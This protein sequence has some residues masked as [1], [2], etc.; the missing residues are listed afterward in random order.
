MSLTP[1]AIRSR[2][3]SRAVGRRIL[4]VGSVDSTNDLAWAEAI[5]G[6]EHGLA[7]FAEEQRKGRG[8]MGREWFAAKGSSVLCSV[9]LRPEI[10]VERVPLVTAIAALAAADAVDEIAHTRSSIRFPNDVFVRDRKIAGVLVES[11]FIS[12]RPDLFVVGIG[13]NGN[14]T[15]DDFPKELAGI[16]TSLQMENGK[17]VNL[18]LAAR[19]LLEALDRWAGELGGGLR[20]IR[21]EW[22]E[23]SA[24][25][26]RSVRVR[27][28]GRNYTGVVEGLDPIEGLEVR[29]AAGPVRH[30]CGEHVEHLELA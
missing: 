7:I 8:R 17:A 23:R 19:S 6:A 11:R 4:C 26:G 2:L 5:K 1:Q 20:A 21:R 14:V 9:V 30:F 18:A 25:L 27:E 13:I 10:D 28:G 12:G 22:R 29:L 3:T 15:Q 16:A 24:I